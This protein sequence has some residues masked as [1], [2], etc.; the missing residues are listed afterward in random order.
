VPTA[1][2]TVEAAP[3]ADEP[4]AA[5]RPAEVGLRGEGRTTATGQESPACGAVG[6]RFRQSCC[7]SPSEAVAFCR[8][9]TRASISRSRTWRSPF[10]AAWSRTPRRARPDRGDPSS[11][12]ATRHRPDH[13]RP[14][15]TSSWLRLGN[16][17]PAAARPPPGVG[18][19]RED[20]QVCPLRA[21][22]RPPPRELWP[23]RHGLQPFRG[24]GSRGWV[25]ASISILYLRAS[26]TQG[27]PGCSSRSQ[28]P[29]PATTARP[30]A[31]RRSPT[32]IRRCTAAFRSST[33]PRSRI[34]IC[35]RARI[36]RW[37]RPA[38][39]DPAAGRGLDL[40]IWATSADWRRRS[41]VRHLL[42]RRSRPAERALRR[43]LLQ[44]A[45]HRRPEARGRRQPLVLLGRA[46]RL[47]PVRRSG[48]RGLRRVGIE[49]EIAWQLELRLVWA[50]G[51]GS[52][53]RR[54]AGG[55]LLGSRSA[56]QPRFAA[57]SGA[58][59]ALAVAEDR[60]R[61]AARH[62]RRHR[63]DRRVRRQHDDSAQRPP[64]RRRRGPG[65]P[66]LEAVTAAGPGPR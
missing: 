57:L 26:A 45:D 17:R 28:R 31:R 21:P 30:I 54:C 7:R 39:R 56:I 62:R 34:S 46:Q 64:V 22:E 3:R 40:L 27:Q 33:T 12:T 59:G 15:S 29:G 16:D 10:D 60:L 14:T 11:T 41:A 9:S 63:S 24:P 18:R 23:R 8:P 50:V 58:V 25:S 13:K 5:R 47:R 44:P 61:R 20:R 53:S 2:P 35:R 37:P 51:S 36:R 32:P 48:S 43:P 19:L 52:S 38:A 65:H 55:A 6:S 49:A 66:A 1:A 4:E 42:R